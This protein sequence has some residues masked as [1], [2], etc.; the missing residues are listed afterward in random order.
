MGEV[1]HMHKDTIPKVYKSPKGMRG[2]ATPHVL[3]IDGDVT[4]N[5]SSHDIILC[6][7]V[8]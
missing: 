7:C 3:S 2:H 5:R 8:Y 4:N 6:G 1:L